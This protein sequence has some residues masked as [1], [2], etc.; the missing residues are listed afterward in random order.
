MTTTR[1]PLAILGLL[2]GVA[3][4]APG[5]NAVSASLGRSGALHVTKNCAD[6]HGQPG[7]FCT[8]TSS[9][10]SEI[11][12]GAKVVYTQPAGIPANM[13]DS[14]VLLDAGDGSRA[15]GRC[16]LDFATGRGLCTF[17]D[18]TGSFA[19]FHARVEVSPP[20]SAGDDWHWRGTYVFREGAARPRDGDH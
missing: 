20:G 11:A 2:V 3:V 18:G 12:P 5:T 9:N 4:V 17:S 10:L 8:V 15:I 13:L 6:Y 7:E 1:G 16:T 14:N 19:G